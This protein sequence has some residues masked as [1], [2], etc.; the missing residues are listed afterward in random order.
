MEI[1]KGRS[2]IMFDSIDSFDALSRDNSCI[3]NLGLYPFD[4]DAGNYEF[5]DKVGQIVGNFIEFDTINIHFLPYPD[6]DDNNND[7][8][9]EA[10]IPDWETLAR[11]LSYLR[12]N[13]SLSLSEDGDDAEVEQI[14][15]L[16]RVIHGHP[17]ISGFLLLGKPLCKLRP[18]VL[19]LGN[20]PLS[21]TC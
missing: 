1:T 6:D 3:K 10:R 8:G 11:I 19:Y 18:L 21:R 15:G 14:Q 2:F 13:V 4:S 20:A 16:G 7:D 12:Q 9:D 5:W 17:R